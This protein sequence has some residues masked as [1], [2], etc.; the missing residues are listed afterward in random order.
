MKRSS[1]EKSD[2]WWLRVQN[3]LKI[4]PIDSDYE[5]SGVFSFFFQFLLC[6]LSALI[7]VSLQDRLICCVALFSCFADF[8]I[9]FLIS[10]FADFLKS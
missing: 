4:E 6:F 8:P 7:F 5:A 3:N 10:C 1:I 2:S 9:D